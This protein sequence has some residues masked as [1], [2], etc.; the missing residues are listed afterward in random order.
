[1]REVGWAWRAMERQPGMSH[2]TR[3]EKHMRSATW[4]PP[5]DVPCTTYTTVHCATAAQTAGHT[6]M[7]VHVCACVYRKAEHRLSAHCFVGA[8]GL[9]NWE[10]LKEYS[11]D[12]YLVPLDPPVCP[13]MNL[14]PL[15]SSWDHP[16]LPSVS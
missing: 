13:S 1:M 4:L 15:L 10:S 8:I 5:G 6:S 7:L 3:V 2:G 12:S 16:G 14:W 11:G 9:R